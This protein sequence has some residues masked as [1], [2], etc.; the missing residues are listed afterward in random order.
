MRFAAAATTILILTAALAGEAPWPQK[1]DTVYISATLKSV[2]SA[3]LVF[4]ASPMESDVPPCVPLTIRKA[5]AELWIT[6]DPVGQSERLE[7]PW[8]PR[9]HRTEKECKDHFAR[10]AEPK[11][12]RSGWLHK[13][14]AERTTEEKK[15]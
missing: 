5:K 7:G 4:G 1:G 14:I 12:V 15:N 9:M 6:K 8:L 13:I 11:V 3:V 2:N 10:F